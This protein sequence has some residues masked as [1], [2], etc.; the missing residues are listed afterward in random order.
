PPA[1]APKPY[2]Q[3]H[4]GSLRPT[5]R[6][7]AALTCAR[8]GGA[9]AHLGTERGQRVLAALDEIAAAHDAEVATVALAWLAAQPTV[10]APLA[11]ARTVEQLPALLAVADLELTD[12]EVARLTAASA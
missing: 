3:P 1:S 6:P 8:G 10:A 5:H 12:A 4:T 7:G 11:S 2:P 9:S